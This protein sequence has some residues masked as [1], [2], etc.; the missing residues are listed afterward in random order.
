M[1]SKRWSK[2]FR[3]FVRNLEDTWDDLVHDDTSQIEREFNRLIGRLQRRHGYAPERALDELQ[4]QWET[5]SKRTQQAVQKQWNS[6]PGRKPKRR[7]NWSV[8][9]ITA[10]GGAYVLNKIIRSNDGWQASGGAH[11]HQADKPENPN[12][13]DERSWESF[14]ASDPPATW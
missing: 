4:N 2:Q 12:S 8:L 5:Y 14:P 13:V 1:S 7:M 3:Q 6:L 11:Q 9:L 10:I